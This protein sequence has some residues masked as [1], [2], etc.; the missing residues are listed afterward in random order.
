MA[1][2]KIFIPQTRGEKYVKELEI[3]FDWN[4][5]NSIENTRECVRRMH[6]A[7]YHRFNLKNLFEV[8]GASS[9]PMGRLLSAFQLP[10]NIEGITSTVESVYQGSKVFE[11]G[12]PYQD[13]Y[14]VDSRSAKKDP[15]LKQSGKLIGF[16]LLDIKYSSKPK[17]AFYDMIYIGALQKLIDET[18]ISNMRFIKHLGNSGGFTDIYFNHNKAINCQARSVALY[19]SLRKRRLLDTENVFQSYDTLTGKLKEIS[20]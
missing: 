3:Y 17:T 1:V 10:I 12:G 11:N 16:Q 20:E 13:L 14:R 4:F 18:D 8:S 2:R 19:V 5:G 15:R 6:V 7:A 9:T